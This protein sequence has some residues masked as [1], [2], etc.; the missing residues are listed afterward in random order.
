[1]KSVI[2][3]PSRSPASSCRKCPAPEIIGCSIPAAPGTVRR[4]TGRH[5]PG[6]RVAV[7]ERHQ[8]RL[9]PGGQPPPR[10]PVSV[11][12][13]VIRGGRHQVRHGPHRGLERWVGKRGFVGRHVRRAPAR[14]GS[15]RS[16]AGPRSSVGAVRTISRNRSQL[17]IG[18]RPWATRC[19]TPLPGRTGPDVRPPA[20]ARSG[21]PSPAPPGSA[22]AGRARR[23]PARGSTPRGA[24]SVIRHV[25]G[26]SERPNPTRSA[27]MT[28]SPASTS[29]GITVRYRNDQLGSPCSSSTGSPP[30]GPAST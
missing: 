11:G 28:R 9:V 21:R 12:R 1:M 23:R 7:A 19:W 5:G 30:G 15:R 13:R 22:R 18:G 4:K 14:S 27:A 29:T 24:V 10:G 17:G 25:T 2:T 3:A 26:L 6:D 20:A 16:P 8:E